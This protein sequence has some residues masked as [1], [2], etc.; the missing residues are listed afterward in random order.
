[1][2]FAPASRRARAFRAAA[3]ARALASPPSASPRSLDFGSQSS[4]RL[5]GRGS[6]A[7]ALRQLFARLLALQL[8]SGLSPSSAPPQML[9]LYRRSSSSPKQLRSCPA[10]AVPTGQR[11]SCCTLRHILFRGCL[12]R[13]FRPACRPRLH[14]PSC[15]NSKQSVPRC[16][17]ASTA[18]PSCLFSRSHPQASTGGTNCSKHCSCCCCR[19]E[20]PPSEER[21]SSQWQH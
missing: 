15:K 17:T 3:F 7:P 2:I 1:M 4:A 8:L 6:R 13:S 12:L 11:H 10:G 9:L 21:C 19:Q 14:S 5:A 20:M 18:A 16:C